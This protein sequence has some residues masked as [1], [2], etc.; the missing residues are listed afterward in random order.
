MFV[1]LALFSIGSVYF[2]G[3][4]GTGATYFGLK[5]QFYC[6]MGYL[7]FI[8]VVVKLTSAGLIWAWSSEIF[9]WVVMIGLTIKYLRSRKWHQ[10]KF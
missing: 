3:L 10:L 1:I 6:A 4:A 9:Y 7:A 8:F 5:I 2:N